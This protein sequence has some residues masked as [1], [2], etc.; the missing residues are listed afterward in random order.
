MRLP[1]QS[2]PV[3]RE[4]L[5]REGRFYGADALSLAGWRPAGRAVGPDEFQCQCQGTECPGTVTCP[6]GESCG[7][8][9]IGQCACGFGDE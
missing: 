1:V 8:N 9:L 5:H 6:K 7:C 2:A 3:I 4:R